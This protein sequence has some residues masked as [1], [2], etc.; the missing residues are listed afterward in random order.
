MKAR[1][2]SKSFQHRSTDLEIRS[3]IGFCFLVSPSIQLLHLETCSSFSFILVMQFMKKSYWFQ[4]SHPNTHP[5]PPPAAVISS[6][7]FYYHCLRPTQPLSCSGYNVHVLT[8]C[9]LLPVQAPSDL[10]TSHHSLCKHKCSHAILW[11]QSLHPLHG[12]PWLWKWGWH[13]FKV[14]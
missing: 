12:C 10:F 5:P 9:L 11:C 7:H 8:S 1:V 6:P 14:I 4:A 13:S 3:P 2:R